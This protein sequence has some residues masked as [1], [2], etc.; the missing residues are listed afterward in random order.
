MTEEN[1]T[2]AAAEEQAVPDDAA[3]FADDL[4]AAFGGDYGEEEAKVPE[5]EV[6]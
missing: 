4:D 3:N 5:E 1:E 2:P 6:P